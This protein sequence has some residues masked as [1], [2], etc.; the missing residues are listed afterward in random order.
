MGLRGSDG[1]RWPPRNR[2]HLSLF[3][4][5]L[6]LRSGKRALLRG[7]PPH[8]VVRPG[9]RHRLHGPRADGRTHSWNAP[10]R[11]PP[12]GAAGAGGLP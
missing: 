4:A 3:L 2:L 7:P 11:V 1:R 10:D 6:P 12:A 5:C 9:A 8:G